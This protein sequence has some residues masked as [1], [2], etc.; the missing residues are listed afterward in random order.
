MEQG[1][2]FEDTFTVRDSDGIVVDMSNYTVSGQ[3]RRHYESETYHTLTA[4]GTATGLTVSLTAAQ[5]ANVE[6]G[7]WVYDVEVVSTSN[8]VSKPISGKITVK[9]QITR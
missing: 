7:R 3:M 8:V 1:S 4:N 9:P 2:D 5:T 6:E